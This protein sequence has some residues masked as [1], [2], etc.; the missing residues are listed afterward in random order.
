MAGGG[1]RT[2][3]GS[4]VL[5]RRLCCRYHSAPCARPEPP[6]PKA[7][8][9]ASEPPPS[10]P[11]NDHERQQTI[12]C[13]APIAQDA[14]A[15]QADRLLA[16]RVKR[17]GHRTAPSVSDIQK[18]WDKPRRLYHEAW[19]GG[20]RVAAPSSTFAAECAAAAT[21]PLTGEAPRAPAGERSSHGLLE[22]PPIASLARGVESLYSVRGSGVLASKVVNDILSVPPIADALLHNLPV[23][24]DREG[25]LEIQ[26]TIAV[27]L[28]HRALPLR[29]QARHDRA[30]LP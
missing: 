25:R 23:N 12:M 27:I 22:R 30:R 20:Q 14:G 16:R 11:A 2:I 3:I 28:S 26:L 18:H 5:N 15:T 8:G 21:L 24:R 19:P 1:Q 9:A 7:K 17:D 4:G 29:S 13:G 6:L 10:T